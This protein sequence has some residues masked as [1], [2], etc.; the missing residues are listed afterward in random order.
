MEEYH[1]SEIGISTEGSKPN[2]LFT[3]RLA[4]DPKAAPVHLPIENAAPYFGHFV[5]DPGQAAFFCTSRRTAPLRSTRGLAALQRAA[6]AKEAHL[7]PKA[8]PG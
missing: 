4:T 2:P 8:V 3:P 6:A 1:I 5:A 7:L